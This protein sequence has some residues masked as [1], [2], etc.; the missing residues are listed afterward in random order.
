MNQALLRQ[1][2]ARA[3]RRCEYCH[4]P[5]IA[6]P[7]PFHIDHIVARQHG[8]TSDINNLALACLHCNRHKGPNIAGKDPLTGQTIRLYDPRQD[9]WD[10]HFRWRGAELSGLTP[11][12]R[13]TIRVLAVN[14]EDFAAVRESLMVEGIF[15]AS[16]AD[17]STG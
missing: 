7:L 11:V 8:G 1:V 13:V 2:W 12:G 10:D 15:Q 4:L 16:T 5:A 3:K 17:V 9:S 6:Y 14:A